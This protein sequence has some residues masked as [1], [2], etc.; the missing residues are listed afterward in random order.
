MKT[1][2]QQDQLP[3]EM[4]SWAERVLSPQPLIHSTCEIKN[5][6]IGA[7]C[8]LGPGCRLHDTQ[9]GAYSY[10]HEWADIASTHVGRFCSIASHVRIN[11]G[12]HPTDRASQHH[13]TYRRRLYGI[14]GDDDQEFF[15]WRKSH[16]C[17]IGHD[18]WIG[19]AATIM[20]GTNIG[21]GA[22]I[23]AGAV[24]TRDVA[25]YTIVAGVPAKII[26]QRCS[27]EDA[28]AMERIGWWWWDHPTLSEH[29][30]LLSLSIKEFIR[31]C[32]IQEKP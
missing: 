14:P 16:S 20:P 17:H 27:E 19:H 6:Q 28:Q 13:C 3:P 30:D 32:R 1:Y 8:E 4:A 29:I 7:Y 18:V 11:P 15:N 25:P 26:R 2:E 22:V 12:N 5:T 23:G 31:T 24:V 10:C 9:F 21:N